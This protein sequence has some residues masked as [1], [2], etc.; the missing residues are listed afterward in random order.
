MPRP[1]KLL[2]LFVNP[3]GRLSPLMTNTPIH[4]S[5]IKPRPRPA[6]TPSPPRIPPASTFCPAAVLGDAPVA[7][8]DVV[9]VAPLALLVVPD[10]EPVAV[11]AV[12][13]AVPL[14]V[15]LP[16]PLAT[17]PPVPIAVLAPDA[18]PLFAAFWISLPPCTPFVGSTLA[19]ANAAAV[20]RA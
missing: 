2:F 19:G 17:T 5:Q 6:T 9:P 3:M 15:T 11:A 7:P 18:E 10:P 16:V 8:A 12:P 20:T 4:V 14:T 1:R 13:V